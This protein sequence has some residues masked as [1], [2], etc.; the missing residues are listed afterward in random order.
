MGSDESRV[1]RVGAASSTTA[2]PGKGLRY[3]EI[4]K[5]TIVDLLHERGDHDKATTA[6]QELPEK[7][8]HEQHSDLLERF[9]VEPQELLGKVGGRLGL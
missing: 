9:G 5:Q 4:D 3:M 7:V 6:E 8:D 1:P 2:G